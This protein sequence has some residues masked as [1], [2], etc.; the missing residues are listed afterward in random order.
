MQSSKI[1]FLSKYNEIL[2]LA[3]TSSADFP[4]KLC[5]FLTS[6]FELDAAVLFKVNNSSALETIG[7]SLQ[8]K[9]S[10][11]IGSTHT[12]TNCQIFNSKALV[13]SFNPQN[14]CSIH[15]TDHLINEGC[16]VLNL[17]DDIRALLKIAKKTSFTKSEID[18][19]QIIAESFKVL[20]KLWIQGRGSLSN[21]LSLIL[22]SIS[23]ELRTPTNSIMGFASLLNEENLSP[24][25]AEY[26]STLKDNA[27]ELLSIINDLIDLSKLE[28][29]LVKTTFN[30]IRLR[31]FINELFSIFKEKVDPSKVEFITE[32]DEVIPET[33]KVDGQK[34]RYIIL[35]FLTNSLRL[36]EKGKITLSATAS[37]NKKISFR[38][39]DTSTGLPSK[40]VMEFFNPFSLTE[41]YNSKIG[42][43]TG[44]SLTLSK[45]YIE[46]L[47]GDVLITSSIGKG[48]TYNFS[49]NAELA[50]T[51]DMGFASIPK[52]TDKKNKVL[53]VEDDYATSKLLSNYLSKWGYEPVIVNSA[54]Q[55]MKL[56]NQESFL[57]V[58]MDIV[59]PDMNGFEFMKMVREHPNSKH[60]PVIICSVEAEQ[61][62]AFMMGAVEYFVKPIN[63]KYLVE[64][65]TSYKLK[66]NSNILIVD[67]DI[68]TLNLIKGAVEQAGFNAI[69]EHQSSKVANMIE[70]LDL[71]LAIIDLDMPVLNGFDLIKQMKSKKQFAKLP[72]IIYTEK[73]SYQE[74]LKKIDGLFTELLHKSSTNIENLADTVAA[75]INRYDEPAAPEDIKDK[76]DSVKILLVEDYKHSQIIVPRLMK[77]NNF[78]SIVVVENGLQALE[79]VNR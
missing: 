31:D 4:S 44:L 15:I 48:I 25:Q 52:P 30:S 43:I 61:Q 56:I 8:V 77:K 50:T 33:I 45:K 13:D 32:I 2:S 53:V 3:V 69:A 5:E 64:V 60:T 26:V 75:M 38:I 46:F 34:L 17:G 16:M 71:D 41:L 47:G 29:G 55:A 42:N 36:T 1:D 58:L 49:V 63:Y 70:N 37:S 67:D 79:A 76:T 12:C 21:S 19:I 72:I 28:S 9:K 35:S 78:D 68:P 51:L 73:D 66:K 10:I 39:S 74:N 14:D 24:S 59:L 18:N 57:A 62:K 40:K 11:I 7:K 27:F 54:K 6:E 20:L 65:L 23:Q 22:S